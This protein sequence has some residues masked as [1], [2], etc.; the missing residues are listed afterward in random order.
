[1]VALWI[2]RILAEWGSVLVQLFVHLPG[3]NETQVAGPEHAPGCGRNPK[4]GFSPFE[5]FSLL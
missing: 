4:P 1:M 2:V 3:L 5:E